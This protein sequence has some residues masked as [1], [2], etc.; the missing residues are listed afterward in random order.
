MMMMMAGR[1]FYFF[2]FSFIK[3]M[4]NTKGN[5]I[6]TFLGKFFSI[7][8]LLVFFLHGYSILSCVLPLSI[9]IA[10]YHNHIYNANT[11]ALNF[12]SSFTYI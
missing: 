4:N 8:K 9:A 5:K 6:F 11:D 2:S 1:T 7:K 10:S 12:F 3:M